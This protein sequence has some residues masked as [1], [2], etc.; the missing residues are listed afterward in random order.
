MQYCKKKCLK[1]IANKLNILDNYTDANI[2]DMLNMAPITAR[3]WRRD[4]I[5]FFLHGKS[6]ASELL[7]IIKICVPLRTTD[8]FY[9][10]IHR[11]NYGLNNFIT[12]TI[13]LANQQHDIDLFES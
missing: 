11:S 13:R 5:T 9:Q 3:H 1:E 12:R 8:S 10:P 6:G 4:L 2:L 7:Q